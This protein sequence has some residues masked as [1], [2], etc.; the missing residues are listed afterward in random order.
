MK[1]ETEL[2]RGYQLDLPGPYMEL[3]PNKRVSWLEK[4]NATKLARRDAF[5]VTKAL[6][7]AGQLLSVR[8]VWRVRDNR[9][10]DISNYLS[11][12][13][14]TIDGICDALGCDD[15]GVKVLGGEFLDYGA[16]ARAGAIPMYP[17]SEGWSSGMVVYLVVA[18]VKGGK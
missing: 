3:S 16:Y 4:A 12:G 14:P 8:Y 17:S 7:I 2:F 13:K 11:M 10:R 18:L 5:L 1:R 6:G 15:Q 9:R